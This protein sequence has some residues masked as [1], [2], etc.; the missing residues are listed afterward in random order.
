[1]LCAQVAVQRASGL[2]PADIN[3]KADPYVLLSLGDS[4]A[5]SSVVAAELNPVWGE[6][7]FL[8]VR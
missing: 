1:V 4:S 8:Y 5:R 3:G 7:F 2:P 6:T